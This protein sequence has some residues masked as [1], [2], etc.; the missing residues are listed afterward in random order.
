[1]SIKT[2]GGLVVGISFGLLP[3]YTVAACALF[4]L[5]SLLIVGV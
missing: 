1:M 5:A 2:I 4:I 3:V